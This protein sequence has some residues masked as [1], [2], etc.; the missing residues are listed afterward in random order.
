M[1]SVPKRTETH[2]SERRIILKHADHPDYDVSI[3]CYLKHGGYEVLKQAVAS[4]KPEDLC[5]EVMD[6]EVR[7]RGGAGQLGRGVS[8][9][10]RRVAGDV[11]VV[12]G[13]V[14]S[15]IG[16]L[17]RGAEERSAVVAGGAAD[18][19]EIHGGGCVIHGGALPRKPQA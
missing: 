11:A 2:P 18:V 7:G 6:S 15:G 8:K 13:G 5:Q 12:D 9:A 10:T 4:R 3:D 16:R 19:G 1:I 14:E 17:V